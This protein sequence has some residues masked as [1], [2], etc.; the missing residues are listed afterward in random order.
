MQVP[1]PAPAG[2]P[3]SNGRCGLHRQPSEGLGGPEHLTPHPSHRPSLV[4]GHSGLVDPAEGVRMSETALT[5]RHRLPRPLRTFELP[6]VEVKALDGLA[7]DSVHE[8]VSP[9]SDVAAEYRHVDIVEE[10]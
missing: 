6:D 7:S 4:V 5:A 8:D 3:R 2:N 10:Q 1:T 9:F